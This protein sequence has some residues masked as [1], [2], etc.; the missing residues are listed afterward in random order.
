MNCRHNVRTLSLIYRVLALWLFLVGAASANAQ[1]VSVLEWDFASSSV[2]LKPSVVHSAV[3]TSNSLQGNGGITLSRSATSPVYLS[4]GTTWAGTEDT[5]FYGTRTSLVPR[6]AKSFSTTFTMGAQANG[7]WSNLSIAMKYQRPS[8]APTKMRAVLT[9]L[10]SGTYKRAYTSAATFSG[11]SWTGPT[12]ARFQNGDTLPTSLA[13]LQCLLE[14][15]FWGTSTTPNSIYVDDVKLLCNTLA[16]GWT[17]SPSSLVDWPVGKYYSL[18]P[19]VINYSGTAAWAVTGT[20]PSGLSLNAS[21]GEISGTPTATGSSSFTLTATGAGLNQSQALTLNM[22]VAPAGLPA[23]R[24]LAKWTFD[25]DTSATVVNVPVVIDPS[26]TEVSWGYDGTSG[27]TGGLSLGG[28]GASSST[29]VN[30]AKS[31]AMRSFAN[32]ASSSSYASTRNS[33]LHFNTGNTARFAVSPTTNTSSI[34][35]SSQTNKGERNALQVRLKLDPDASG[36]LSAFYFDGLRWTKDNMTVS[37]VNGPRWAQLHAYWTDNNG[38]LQRWDSDV[39]DVTSIY[40]P[41][42]RGASQFGRYWFDLDA[43]TSTGLTAKIKATT[44]QYNSRTIFF[45]LYFWY[46][47]GADLSGVSGSNPPSILLDEMGV[48]GALS[49]SPCPSLLSTYNVITSSGLQTST[50]IEGRAVVNTITGANAFTAARAVGGNSAK[51][52]LLVQGNVASGGTI[53]MQS[54]SLY[55][56]AVSQLN[57]RSVAYNGG[58]STVTTPSFDF[59]SVFNAMA[60]ESANYKA[61]PVNSTVSIPASPGTATLTVNAS[62][63]SNDVAVFSVPGNSLFNNSNVQ[64]IDLNLN[65]TQ[66]AWIVV[67]VTGSS[68]GYGNSGTM[69]GNLVSATWRSRLLWNFPQA[70]TLLFNKT[71]YGAIMAPNAT[72]TSTSAIE[73]SVAVK[74]LVAG[75]EVHL[76]LFQGGVCTPTLSIG[77]L[78]WA[79]TNNNGI[80]DAGESGLAGVTVQLFSTGTDNAIGGSGTAADTQ[81]GSSI[82]TDATGAYLFTGLTA[83]KYFVKVTPPAAYPY[84]GGTPVTLDN[85]VDNDN[86]GSQPGG[87]GTALFSPVI[88]LGV[89]AESITDADVDPNTD[90]TVDFGL[91]SGM[92]IGNLVWNDANDN[93]LFDSGE[94][95]IDNVLVELWSP[96]ADGAIGGSGT[97]ADTKVASTTT[98]GGGLYSFTNLVAG[99]Y[100]VKIP[101]APLSHVSLVVDATD[102]GQDG[103]NNGAQPG[104]SG[105]SVYSPVITLAA[106]AE[107]GGVGS[108]NVDNTIDFGFVGN[109]GSPFV[110]DNR[111]YMIQSV[112]TYS[113]S[114]VFD[115]TLYYVGASTTLVPLYIFNGKRLNGLASYAGFLYCVDQQGNHLYRINSLGVLVDMGAVSGLPSPGS[116]GQWSGATAL[117]N[118]RMVLN[119]AIYSTTNSTYLY[120]IDLASATLVGSGVLCVNSLTSQP[121]TANFGDIALDPLTGNV[122]GYAT[123]DSLQQGLWKMDVA[124]GKCTQISVGTVATYGSLAIDA[125]GIAYGYGSSTTN[126]SVQNTLYL[127]N[128]TAGVL[129]GTQTAVGTGPSVSGTDGAACPGSPPSMTIGNL[130]WYDANNNGIKD[131]NESGIPGVTLKLFVGGQNPAADTPVATTTTDSNGAYLFGNLAPGQYFV[132]I[133]SPPAAYPSTSGTPQALDNGVDNDN[134][135]IQTAKSQPITSPLIALAPGTE[136]VN[137]GDSDANTNLSVDFGLTVSMSIGNLVW[138]DTNNN[139]IKD[140]SETGIGGVTV[141]L[142]SPGADNTV[143]TAD[144]VQ[145]GANV[146]TGVT[147][148]YSFS[149]LLPGNYYVKVTPPTAYPL[150]SGTPATADNSVDNNNDGSQPG[151]AGT[152]LYSPIITL[153]PGAESVADGDTDPNTNLTVDFGFYTGF[154]VG[155]LVWYDANNNGIKDASEVGIAGLTVELLNGSGASFVPAITTTTNSSGAYGFT[156]YQAGSYKIKATPNAAYPRASTTVGLDNG[157]DNNNDGT[158]AGGAGSPSI[159]FAFNL[160]AGAEPGTAGTANTENTIDFGFTT[161]PTITIT[162]A[163]LT[164][165]TVGTGYNQSLAASGG[166]APYTWALVSGTLPTGLALSSGGVISGTPVNNT[167]QTFT[168][169]A[170][171][172]KLCPATMSYTMTPFWPSDYGDYSGFTSNASSFVSTSIR[173]GALV[174]AETTAVTNATA[175]GDDA[176]GSADEDGVTVPKHLNQG[177]AATILVNVTNTSGAPAYL[178]GWIDFNNNG[179]LTESN[180]QVATNLVI[181]TGTVNS[182]QTIGIVVPV[183][184]VTAT[185]GVRFR[186]T[187]TISPGPTGASGIG[188]VEDDTVIIYP[189]CG[190]SNVLWLSTSSSGGGRLETYNITTGAKAIVGFTSDS[191]NH[192]LFDLAWSPD[193]KLYGLEVSNGK[194]NVYLISSTTAALTRL[195][196]VSGSFNGMVFDGDGT[197]YVGSSD[198]GGIYSFNIAGLSTSSTSPVA[199]LFDAPAKA[200]NGQSL[201]SGGDLAFVGADL[202]YAAVGGTSK[203][204]LYKVPA[205]SSNMQLVG[206]MVST[207]GAS[208]PNVYGLIG[209]GYGSIY[210]QG[211]SNLY[212]LNRTNAVATSLS[213]GISGNSIYGGAM[214]FE[215]CQVNEDHGDY[216][217]FDDASSTAYTSLRMGALVDGEYAQANATASSDDNTGVDDEDGVTVPAT[218]TPGQA[219]SLVVNVTNTNGATAYL[220]AWIDFN[221]DGNLTD[222]GEQ[223]A[224]NVTVA[225]GTSG[226]NITLNFN[227]PITATPGTVGVRVRLTS[228]SSPGPTGASGFGEVEDYITTVVSVNMSIGNLVWADTNNNGIKDAGETGIGGVTVQLFSPGADNLVGT[229]DD[230]QVGSNAVTGVTG[231]Y[232]FTS[233][234]PGKYYVKVL[235]LASYPL[236]SGTPATTDNNVDNNNDGSQPGGAGTPLYSPIITLA[237][238]TESITDGDTDANTNLTVDFGLFTGFT[239]GNLV[240]YDAN[241]NGVKDGSEVGIAGL[242]VELLNS[243]GASFSPAVT[244]TTNSSGAYGFSVY[245]AGTYKVKVIPGAA[246]PRASSAVGTD[247]AT[248]NN[249][250]GTQAGGAGSASISFP[251]TLTAGGEPGTTGTSN[252][253]NTIDFGFTTCPTIAI[254]PATL[255][256]GTV[257]TLYNQT[258]SA[259]GGTAPYSWTVLSGTLP[260]GLS[261]TSAGVLSG[262]PSTPGTFFF[263]LSATDAGLCSGS[264]SYGVSVACPSITMTPASLPA[265]TV[266]SAYSATISASGGVA[267]YSYS[268]VSGSL[269]AGLSLTTAGVLSGNPSSSVGQTFSIKAIDANGCSGTLSYTLTAGCP[270]I[271]LTPSSIPN[272]TIG[273]AYSQVLSATGGATPYVW[274]VS[275]G[276]LPAGLTLSSVGL[277]SG[278][279][280]S[281][282]VNTFTVQAADNKGCTGAITYT[283]TPA[284]T[285]ITVSP[286]SP[287]ASVVGTP[288]SQTL[289][290]TGGTSPYVWSV[291]S[292]SLPAGLTLTSAGVL[293][294]TPTSPISQTFTVQAVDAAGC[295]GS[296]AYTLTSSCPAL[297]ITP[298]TLGSAVVG[299]LYSQAF[300][301]SGGTSPYTWSVSS[302]SLPAGLNL[303]SSGVLGGTPTSITNQTFTIRVV[304]ANGCPGTKLYTMTPSCPAVTIAP[305]TLPNGTQGTAYSQA[306]TAT[307]GTS[308]YTWSVSSGSLP[309]GL[310]LSSAGTISGTP[311]NTTSQSFTVRAADANGCAGT[312]SYTMVPVCAT[313]TVAPA[314]LPG[315]VVG[316][317]YNQPLTANGG[318]APYAWSITS[319]TLPAGLTLSSAGVISGTPTSTASHTLTVQAADANGCKGTLSYTIAPACPAITITPGTLPGAVTGSAYSQALTAGGSSGTL[320]W[321]VTSGSLPSGLVLGSTGVISGIP[322]STTS[323]T[324]TIQATDGNGCPSTITYTLAPACPTLSI[325][326]ATLSGAVVGSPYSQSLSAGGGTGT[327]SWAITSGT[328]PAGLTLNSSTGLISGTAP[329][330]ASSTALTVQVTDGLGCTGSKSYTFT[331]T[332][333]SIGNLVWND[334]NGNGLRDAGEPGVQ[335][336]TVQLFQ[337]GVDNLPYTADDVQVGVSQTTPADGSYRFDNLSPGSYCLMV[338]PTAGLPLTTANVATADNG[339]DNDNNGSQPGGSGTVLRSPVIVLSP[340]TEPTSEDGDANTDL[341]VDFGLFQGLS[342]GNLVWND[343]NSNGVRDAGE[344]GIAGVLVQLFSAGADGKTGGSDDVLL[345]STTTDSNGAYLFSG[346]L[347]GKYY[348]RLPTPPAATPLATPVASLADNGVDN[349]SNGIQTGGGPVYS[350]V[351]TLATFTEP[352]SAG[353]T[354]QELTI[355]FGLIGTPL[356][357]FATVA[358]DDAVHVYSPDSGAFG[359]VFKRPFGNNTSQGNGDTG[360]VPGGIELGP[361]GNWYVS[362]VGAGNIRKITPSGVDQGMVLS[363]LPGIQQLS[364]FVFGPD[365]NFYVL[366]PMGSRVIRFAGPLNT[367]LTPGVPL[368]GSPYAFI[369]KS[370]RDIAF[371]PDANIYLLVKSGGTYQVERYNAITGAYMN[372]IVTAAQAGSMVSGGETLPVISGIEIRDATLYGVTTGEGEVFKVSLADPASP[373]APVLVADLDNAGLGSVDTEDL[374]LDPVNGLIYVCGYRWVKTV[375]DGSFLSSALIKVDPAAASNAA[376]SF[377]ELVMPTPPG[378]ANETFPGI[379]DVAFGPK[380]VTAAAICSLGSQVW[381][382]LNF[383]GHY[384]AGEPGIPNVKIELWSDANNDL[385]DGTEKLVGWTY[386]DAYGHYLF[387]G[388]VPGRYQAVISTANFAPGGPLATFSLS[389]SIGTTTT[390]NQVDGDNNGYK[391]GDHGGAVCSPVITLAAGDEPSGDA[392]SGTESSAGGDLDDRLGDANGDMTVDFAFYVPGTMGIGNLVFNDINGNSHYDDGEG[393]DGIQVEL[394]ASGQ[395]PGVSLP[396]ATQTTAN[397]GR[398]LFTSLVP[399]SY[400]VFIPPSQFGSNGILRGMFSVPGAHELG[401]DDTGEKGLDV[402]SPEVTGVR[403]AAV[404]LAYGMA[405]TAD[406]VETGFDSASDDA[407]DSDTD[408]T[409]DFGFYTRVGVGNLVFFDANGDGVAGSGEGVAGVTVELYYDWQTPEQDSPIAATV[410]DSLGKYLFLDLQP[411]YYVVHIPSSMFQSGKPLFSYMSI[412]E[413][414]VGDD[415]VGEDG[416]NDTTPSLQ[417]VSSASILLMAGTTPTS[418]NGETGF[419]SA[420]DDA[421]DSAVDLTVDFGFQR[422]VSIGNM[423]FFDANNNGHYDDGE[424][425]PNVQVQL[426][427]TGATA[428]F[429]VPLRSVTTDASGH[430]RFSGLPGGSYFVYIPASQFGAG[431]PL[432]NSMSI[433]GVAPA[434]SDD[435]VGEDGQDSGSPAVTGIRSGDVLLAAGSCPVASAAGAATGENGYLAV[436]DSTNDADGDM[437]IDLG[438]TTPDSTKV[439]VG[440]AVF[441]DLNGNGYYDD[442]EGVGGVTLRLYLASTTAPTEQNAVATT[443]TDSGGGYYFGN[444]APGRYYIIVPGFNFSGTGKLAGQYSLPGQGGDDGLDDDADENGDDPADPSL[445]G[446]RSNVFDLEPGLMPTDYDTETGKD[447]YTDDGNDESSNLT[448]DFGFYTPVGVGNLVFVDAN[449]NGHADAGEGVGGVTVQLYKTGDDPVTMAPLATLVSSSAAVT[450]GSYMF[451]GLLPGSYFLHIPYSMFATGAP[452][453]GMVSMAGAQSNGGDDLTGEDGIDP[454]DILSQG[455]STAVFALRPGTMPS[456][457][458]EGGLFGS[459]DNATQYGDKNY[460]L[461]WDFGFISN[462]KVGNLVF[463]DVDGDGKFSAGTDVGV[464]GVTVQLYRQDTATSTPV[465]SGTTTTDSSGR[466]LF[467][468]PP[469]SYFVKIPASM[470]AADGPLAH[471]QA[472]TLNASGDDDVG[473]DASDGGSPLT[474]GAKTAVF[475]LA[476]GTMPVTATGETGFDSSSDDTSDAESNLTIDLGFKPLPLSVGNLVFRDNDASSTYNAG[477]FGIGGVTVRLFTEGSDPTTAAPVAEAVTKSDGSYLLSAYAAGSY[478]VHIAKDNFATGAPLAGLVSSPGF[479]TDN[480]DDNANENGIDAATP[481]STGINSAPFTLAYGTAPT[482]ATTETGFDAA[483]DDA[484]DADTNL[485]IDFGFR[486]PPVGAPLAGHVRRDL[487]SSGVAATTSPPLGGVELTLYA[488]TAASGTTDTTALT[489]VRTTSTAA[490]GT[491]AFDGLTTG[492]YVVVQTP[493]PGAVPTAAAGGTEPDRA[494]VAIE[495]SAGVAG[496]DF[497][498]SLSPDTFAQWQAQNT[499]YGATGANDNPDGDIY[500]NLFTYALGLDATGVRSTVPFKLEVNA[501]TG[502]IDAVLVRRSG[503]H[504][505]VSYV[506]EGSA[507]FTASATWSRLVIVPAV[508]ANNDGSETVRYPGVNTQ[509]AFAGSTLGYVRLKVVLDANHSGTPQ[510]ASTSPVFAFNLLSLPAAQTTF[511]MPLLKSEVFSGTISAVTNSALSVSASGLKAVLEAGRS[512]YAEVLDGAHEGERYELDE[513]STTDTSVAL[514][515][516]PQIPTTLAGAR[517][518]I[519][520]HW[521]LNEV[522]PAN[523]FHADRSPGAA[524]RVMFFENSAYHIFWV[525]ATGNGPR[526]VADGDATLKN[527]GS[528]RL[529]GPATGLLV[530][531]RTAVTAVP[532]VGQ[533]RANTF[534]VTLNAGPQLV[535]TGWP[536]DQSPTGRVMTAMNGFASGDYIRLWS[537][538]MVPGSAAYLSNIMISPN[539]WAREDDVTRANVADTAMFIAFHATFVMP[540]RAV[541]W[542]KQPVPR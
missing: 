7:D 12:T 172:S 518:V 275:T 102:N 425:V 539:T 378:P 257:G 382:D 424:G 477:D 268:L 69:I 120:T 418:L 116:T 247:N 461:T 221:A 71:F 417:G 336:A 97:N 396:I 64:Q 235:P 383:D 16:A 467:S 213:T 19:S 110:C 455:I 514:E 57:G 187:S 95:G 281:V 63:T 77:N 40:N 471:T 178:N 56:P 347:P 232:S 474:D 193:G 238:G 429:T 519:R 344:P 426:Y 359:S 338:T 407:K 124:T 252:I 380:V 195:G 301:V 37:G 355:D 96:G 51:P 465:L 177:A 4:A 29:P 54:G 484:A 392:L 520:P 117:T 318:T 350:P 224:S 537:G 141:Q 156:V 538:D 218:L 460:D 331:V 506:L 439:G 435:S 432:F 153:A 220:N 75:G 542:W 150:T 486:V 183:G 377:C 205:G 458:A 241:N 119:Q 179:L 214:Q 89:G 26:I 49:T 363:N 399:G 517:V 299:T 143:G 297:A 349:D 324:F 370:A 112:E 401:D 420:S 111:F 137:D 448:I 398:Y 341:T 310:T 31:G 39:K 384:Q 200:P 463:R 3:G 35:T 58:G 443:T 372:T 446:V 108:T 154:T 411:G 525:L 226:S 495:T 18:Q 334:L 101:T 315:G 339:V 366:D 260:G 388:L 21:T 287:P 70:T 175:T 464:E 304:D 306:L 8:T 406:T 526:W 136:P 419:D 87:A 332:G 307:G 245:Q 202:Y 394:Y 397:G 185:V 65:G 279:P 445:A 246:Y 133:A 173:M 290:A 139:G 457:T 68:V 208:I 402:E 473:Q 62:L 269:P 433:P 390:D 258:M 532:L 20:L 530:Q 189:S 328:L 452:L 262:T 493:L 50:A 488:D 46:D 337:V 449:G 106:G 345:L 489:A 125:N 253:E 309:S 312:L 284:C 379:R 130:V 389:A 83:G 199:L 491:Y 277:I 105:K 228:T 248:D 72:L 126:S 524:D 160:T 255:T 413:G 364:K 159:S 100:Y 454:V 219:S 404:T 191:S 416:L 166:V 447:T 204:Y 73:G 470:F 239:M 211:D 409:I 515:V 127:F 198:D 168:V 118:G 74:D 346:L 528:T 415:D 414:R 237:P 164:T 192:T 134:N 249:N 78:V 298:A 466:Y 272:G 167:P 522:L 353:S 531:A 261:L 86:N 300:T 60:T 450:K 283:L 53:T 529:I 149:G 24:D 11:T 43:N 55:I 340:G 271:T 197:L 292:G 66:P 478:F 288:Y 285:T 358:N 391:P 428:G 440:N 186:L 174:D 30:T 144:D 9:W 295:K 276:T 479:S 534:A 15:Y 209:D 240:W 374:K 507:A 462:V 184:A 250:D 431:Q 490:D 48:V 76:P 115:T 501:Q 481:S 210:A 496:V 395:T 472:T 333:L 92:T 482:A 128:R 513:V 422:P 410:T 294:G 351:I 114:G 122:Y 535:G 494:A 23:G 36:D 13:G 385:G 146:I 216:S 348:L 121:V 263:S 540:G 541:A 206:E 47:T 282:G 510:A 497:L 362:H 33:L 148:A 223:I 423:V 259:S 236:T 453:A 27:L 436:G 289:S 147:G 357:A 412:A 523:R 254:T 373:G 308:P 170:M 109:A 427:A 386:T 10:E 270:V 229:A 230:V 194:T 243:T 521:T 22:T 5:G 459:A 107:P 152:P 80:K 322:T 142:F 527:S 434:G 32:W 286:S 158:Q 335:G 163:T 94:G 129:N 504:S 500:D 28:S 52:N 162:P 321:T 234:Q 421:I 343:L 131:T 476:G 169:Q 41:E 503:G 456:G 430:Y 67:N 34:P 207:T 278:T 222:A 441:T 38:T 280:T 313:I 231:A 1:S 444:L 323:R 305:A 387:D 487:T 145:V 316:S 329:L 251:I 367:T 190:L 140:A 273:S 393:I 536:V 61:L 296:V 212:K 225:N 135:G 265:A 451:T 215:A 376:P 45:D 233:L 475:V 161:C 342:V 499:R 405:P 266:G 113:G 327:L 511:S 508:E 242:T 90:T 91:Y 492:S 196:A 123:N 361:D 319:G 59:A 516:P 381:N 203:F 442:G 99:Q 181:P 314:S 227:V 317:V 360:D 354:N 6:S 302:G 502:D 138:A 505:D 98:A 264:L 468:V 182:T 176:N 291:S 201:T 14:V 375:H 81:V 498:Q 512:Y 403:C 244:T 330:T 79:D 274:T 356:G 311:T 85:Q 369:A 44:A 365:G 509:P 303:S 325:T 533:V 368:D 400:V 320:V 188:E 408:L 437:T 165:G 469:A 132:Y 171:D 217:L 17:I 88:D 438:F 326:P 485:T 480:G 25:T 93:G 293:S 256:S 151:G 42:Y 157:T 104:G 371:G 267:P 155:N 483:S 82:T 180:E 2:P 84:T 352:G 103:D